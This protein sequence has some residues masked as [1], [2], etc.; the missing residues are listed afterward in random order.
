M[1]LSTRPGDDAPGCCH[2]EPV[3]AH[4]D[5][6]STPAVTAVP[7][8]MRY[9]CPMCPGVGSAVAGACPHCG[10]SLEPAVPA[11]ANADDPELADLRQRF[12]IALL[13]TLPL[14]GYAMTAM[15][16]WI[17]MPAAGGAGA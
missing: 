10:M 12:A 1:K 5:V 8:A 2:A 9:V 13:L 11:P 14:F 17:A 15:L 6:A 3:S 4:A 7:D 16:G